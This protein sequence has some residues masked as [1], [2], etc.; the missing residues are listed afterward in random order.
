MEKSWNFLRYPKFLKRNLFLREYLLLTWFHQPSSIYQKEKKTLLIWEKK[1]S[2]II[3]EY[4]RKNKSYI[5]E[6]LTLDKETYSKRYFKY[7]N[8][9][10]KHHVL[11]AVNIDY[12][13]MQLNLFQK[14]DDIFH[15]YRVSQVLNGAVRLSPLLQQLLILSLNKMIELGSKWE[16]V[17]QVEKEILEIL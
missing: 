4:Y 13:K 9:G 14:K 17:F 6:A 16:L 12:R 3:L 10:K 2:I 11:K 8:N 15:C 7:K 5:I 1:E